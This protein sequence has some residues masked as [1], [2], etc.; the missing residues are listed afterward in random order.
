VLY[1]SITIPS[2]IFYIYYTKP[3]VLHWQGI[4]WPPK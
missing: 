4:D 2:Y 3:S 1:R